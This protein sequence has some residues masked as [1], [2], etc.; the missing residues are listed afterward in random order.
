MDESKY[1]N[2]EGILTIFADTP[3][4]PSSANIYVIPDENGFSLIDV[5]CGGAAGIEYL[6][7]GLRHWRL[8]IEQ[9]HAVVLSHAH[10]DHMGAIGW[11]LEEANPKVFIH[12]LDIGP[13]LD[14]GQL[15]VTFDIPLAKDRWSAINPGKE[16]SDFS[17]L[18]YLDSSGCLMSAAAQV[19]TLPT[20]D[21][22]Q[23]SDFEFHIIH[24]PGH[25]PGH[26]SLFEI[27]RRILLAGDLVGKAPAWY[28]P[29]AGGV[30]GYLE[31]LAK[32]EALGAAILLPAHGPIIEEA[33]QVIQKIKKKL[34]QRESILKEAL[35]DGEKNFMELNKM[36]LGDSHI[37]FFPGC[38]IIESHLIKLEKEGSIKR[39]GQKISLIK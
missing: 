19:E 39:E 26:I 3:D 22:L 12:H 2:V 24:T 29:A 35:Q 30:I 37:N 23:L 1:N 16:L 25:S 21:V 11:I 7:Q 8:K 36:L 17:I 38:G 14:P 9:L 13:A 4:W 32:L 34:L 18:N 10:P 31:S 15:D 33:T 6:K 20:R 28:V 5:G 27:N